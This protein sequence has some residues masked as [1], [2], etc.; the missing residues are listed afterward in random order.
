[1]REDPRVRLWGVRVDVRALLGKNSASTTL[2]ATP[3]VQTLNPIQVLA[4][5]T[6]PSLQFAN[7]PASGSFSTLSGASLQDFETFE[8]SVEGKNGTWDHGFS[9]N[10]Q[11]QLM[12]HA[13]KARVSKCTTSK[14][15]CPVTTVTFNGICELKLGQAPA[16]KGNFIVGAYLSP[17]MGPA[18]SLQVA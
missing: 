18:I 10:G 11:T 4:T 7:N 17:S 15:A 8:G 16:A 13:T 1:M 6:T 9:V 12:A 5:T 2:D 3:L 14:D